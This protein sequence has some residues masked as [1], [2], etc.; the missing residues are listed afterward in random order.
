[1]AD[2]LL[3]KQV[4]ET[5]TCGICFEFFSDARLLSCKHTYCLKCLLDY[6]KTDADIACPNCR[7][8]TVPGKR[9]LRGLPPNGPVN[10]LVAYL[11]RQGRLLNCTLICDPPVSHISSVCSDVFVS[12]ID[13]I[14]SVLY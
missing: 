5:V 3:L 2:N 12:C 6:Q 11:Y 1:M 10:D 4:K 8:D 9:A 7:R 14:V 13:C